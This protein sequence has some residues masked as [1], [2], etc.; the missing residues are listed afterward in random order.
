[1]EN[2][3]N[4]TASEKIFIFVIRFLTDYT[5]DFDVQQRE[6]TAMIQCFIFA[7][8]I[9]LK[10]SGQREISILLGGGGFC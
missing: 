1:M 6:M 3:T 8:Q 5:M 2:C 10:N 7:I 9:D 4:L